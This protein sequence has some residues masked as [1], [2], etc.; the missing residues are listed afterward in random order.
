[1]ELAIA[2]IIQKYNKLILSDYNEQRLCLRF[3][4]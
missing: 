4:Y 1:M 2:M 3:I